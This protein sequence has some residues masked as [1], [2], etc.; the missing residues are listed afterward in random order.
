MCCIARPEDPNERM[1][2]GR[3]RRV[4]GSWDPSLD[5]AGGATLFSVAQ[6]HGVDVGWPSNARA[7]RR[8]G[9]MRREVADG[10]RGIPTRRCLTF[11]PNGSAKSSRSYL[12]GTLC[13]RAL[14]SDL[15]LV[16]SSCH[17]TF[18]DPLLGSVT[19]RCAQHIPRLVAIML[20]KHHRLALRQQGRA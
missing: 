1:H 5:R 8:A 18:S 19:A 12:A 4:L 9:D 6:W 3:L 10:V 2:G 15:L 11:P 20:A 16:G 7:S 17:G 13:Q 14:D